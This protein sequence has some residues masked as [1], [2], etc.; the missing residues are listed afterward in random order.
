[1]TQIIDTPAGDVNPS[2]ATRAEI[3][4][5]ILA[6]EGLLVNARQEE[7]YRADEVDGVEEE[8]EDDPDNPDL[9]DR[10]SDAESDLE[11]ARAEVDDLVR[12]IAILTTARATRFAD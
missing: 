2:T 3:D 11:T 8:R 9:D 12:D 1:M 10:L 7:E 4:A 6:L 5:A